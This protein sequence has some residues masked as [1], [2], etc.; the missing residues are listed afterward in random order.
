[1]TDKMLTSDLD[2]K[3]E[4]VRQSEKQIETQ[5]QLAIASDQRAIQFCAA[6]GV[7]ITIAASVKADTVCAAFLQIAAILM[8]AA[9]AIMSAYS[10]RPISVDGP[11]GRAGPFLER[12]FE[13]AAELLD[14]IA[15]RN[16]RKISENGVASGD[17]ASAFRCAMKLGV[18]G[19]F[20]LI[21]RLSVA[22]VTSF[23]QTR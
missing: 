5:L 9:A 13:D 4:A 10:F 8:L 2:V 19:L 1:M 20:L 22:F 12:N 3:R 21:L 16:D 11:G 6:L 15:R 7:A 23:V 17:N 14:A 18:A